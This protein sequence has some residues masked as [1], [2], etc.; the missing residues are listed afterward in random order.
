MSDSDISTPYLV[1]TAKSHA[2]AAV[3]DHAKA[4]HDNPDADVHEL[5]MLTIK[6]FLRM[7]ASEELSED[8]KSQ[9]NKLQ[10]E[11]MILKDKINHMQKHNHQHND[12]I[13]TEETKLMFLE[14]ELQRTKSELAK[15][16]AKLDFA[17]A[18]AEKLQ[19]RVV[20]W[21]VPEFACMS[22]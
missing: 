9:L 21:S 5:Q 19:K 6:A 1:T 18:N 20:D 8:Y 17:V 10:R 22:L 12:E 11:N 2:G 4:T 16:K 3:Q 15:T 14:E 7:K 13:F